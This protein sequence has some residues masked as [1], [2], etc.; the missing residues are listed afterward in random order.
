M[1]NFDPFRFSQNFEPEPTDCELPPVG[2]LP[3][4]DS[5]SPSTSALSWRA[6]I[7][8]PFALLLLASM[9]S[10]SEGNRPQIEYRSAFE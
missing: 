4:E 5:P 3:Y 10:Q 2:L 1:K 9:W 6:L 8:L 7:I